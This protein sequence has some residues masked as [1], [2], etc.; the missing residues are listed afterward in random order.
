MH[1]TSNSYVISIHSS[2]LLVLQY[3][4]SNPLAGS[5][6]L[7]RRKRRP[8]EGGATQGSRLAPPSFKATLGKN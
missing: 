5:Y 1:G 4:A 8:P 6:P 7:V 2:L 3:H